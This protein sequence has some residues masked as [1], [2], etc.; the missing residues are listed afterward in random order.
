MNKNAFSYISITTFSG[1]AQV[2]SQMAVK[3]CSPVLPSASLVHHLS[4][5]NGHRSPLDWAQLCWKQPDK[6]Q[7]YPVDALEG[8][9]D[10]GFV[11]QANCPKVSQLATSSSAQ[12][13]HSLFWRYIYSPTITGETEQVSMAQQCC[14]LPSNEG[15]AA[16]THSCRAPPVVS[17]GSSALMLLPIDEQPLLE[18]DSLKRPWSCHA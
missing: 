17:H 7:P 14:A 13:P 2:A 6:P 4:H 8:Q 16:F 15:R 10:R 9:K 5:W 11:V 12:L 18:G 1:T 3:G